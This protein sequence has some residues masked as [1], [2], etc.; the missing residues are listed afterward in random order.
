MDSGAVGICVEGPWV[1]AVPHPVLG[2]PT[3]I[4]SLGL[5][6]FKAKKASWGPDSTSR[7]IKAQGR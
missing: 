1:G 7:L 3:G 6:E 4:N 2:R 5:D